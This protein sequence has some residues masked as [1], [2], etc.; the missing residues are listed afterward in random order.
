M[1][2]CNVKGVAGSDQP[3][4]YQPILHF[5]IKNPLHNTYP[6]WRAQRKSDPLAGEE[7][8]GAF[9]VAAKYPDISLRQNKKGS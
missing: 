6:E 4:D 7:H 1:F 5:S 3:T 8:N 2:V 9:T